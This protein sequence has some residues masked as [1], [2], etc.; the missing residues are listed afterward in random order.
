MGLGRGDD[1]AAGEEKFLRLAGP[2]KTIPRAVFLYKDMP[3]Y[4]ECLP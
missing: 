4:K 2:L 1:P 3:V